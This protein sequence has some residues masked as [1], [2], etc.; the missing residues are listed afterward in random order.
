MF[1]QRPVCKPSLQAAIRS[2]RVRCSGAFFCKFNL[3]IGAPSCSI[4]ANCV[5]SEGEPGG[6]RRRNACFASAASR[7]STSKAR[8]GTRLIRAST[9]L[10]SSNRIHSMPKGLVSKPETYIFFA[11][12][13]FRWAS[14]CPPEFPGGDSA[15]PGLQWPAE[16]HGLAFSSSYII[17]CFV[18]AIRT[19]RNRPIKPTDLLPCISR[20]LKQLS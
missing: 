10:S 15:S 14:V 20:A 7:S 16:V 12:G 2:M 3:S 4:M 13:I 8:C 9:G 17:R 18:H 5:P 6:A 19:V 11:A 1:I